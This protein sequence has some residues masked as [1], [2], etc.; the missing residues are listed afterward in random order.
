M[1]RMRRAKK[2]NE[3]WHERNGLERQAMLKKREPR[4]VDCGILLERAII[5]G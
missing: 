1:L 3:E 4:V 5:G 2:V